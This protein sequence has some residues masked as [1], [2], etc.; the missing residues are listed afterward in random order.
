[1]SAH[2]SASRQRVEAAL[3]GALPERELTPDERVVL[4]AEVDA[5]ISETVRTVRFGEVLAAR[6]VTTVALDDEGRLTRYH[7]DGTT[8]LLP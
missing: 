8:S 5:T 3:R 7:P 1:M 2:S 6:G 4:N